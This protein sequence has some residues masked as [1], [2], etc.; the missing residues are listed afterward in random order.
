M[1]KII[2]ARRDEYPVVPIIK[3]ELLHQLGAVVQSPL[4]RR[5]RPV[6][7]QVGQ[8]RQEE[9]GPR[10]RSSLAWPIA[11]SSSNWSNTRTGRTGRPS[12]VCRIKVRR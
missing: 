11:K 9:R 8:F 5:R 12:A 2:L 4:E 7:D 6:F 10:P 1:R 3:D